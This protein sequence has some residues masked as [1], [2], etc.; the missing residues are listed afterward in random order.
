MDCIVIVLSM[1]KIICLKIIFPNVIKSK[2]FQYPSIVFLSILIDSSNKPESKDR[3]NDKHGGVMIYIKDGL[4]Y[5][6]RPDLVPN[7]ISECIWNELIN[8]INM[9]YSGFSR[10]LL[11]LIL[12]IFLHLKI[13]FIYL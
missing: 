9:Y 8:N 4:H 1:T 5:K 6:R 2:E 12:H 7:T 11:T 3:H 10:D 13:T